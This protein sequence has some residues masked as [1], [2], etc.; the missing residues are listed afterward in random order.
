MASTNPHIVQFTPFS[1]LIQPAFWHEL[2]RLKLDVL[3]LS[4][5]EVPVTATY[6]AGR[7]VTDRETGKEVDLGCHLTL[8]GD[9]L[10]DSPTCVALL[11]LT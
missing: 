6:T 3:R 1:S 4:A 7:A 10:G 11:T 8:A 5:E 2:T 9:A